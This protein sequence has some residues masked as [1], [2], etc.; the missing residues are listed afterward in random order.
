MDAP[1]SNPRRHL[2]VALCCAAALLAGCSLFKPKFEKPTFSIVGI[3]LGR[4][5][6]L[7]QHLV[8]RMRVTNP[9]DR[10]LPVEGLSY[11][12]AVNGEVLAR[13]VS[14]ASFVVPASGAAE[15]DTSVTTNMASALLRWLG[16][17]ESAPLNYHFSGKVELSAG[18]I[19]SVPFE[20]DGV[21][22][23]QR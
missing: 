5:D 21:L 2:V 1:E 7:Q 16:R 10:A 12:F 11:T 9:N 8:V 19:R 22:D 17:R 14:D 18:L 4:S 6:L 20:R 3:T 13:G 15:F 23:L